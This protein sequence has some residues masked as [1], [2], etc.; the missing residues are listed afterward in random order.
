MTH[1]QS[2]YL[3]V[4]C[5]ALLAALTFLLT[6]IRRVRA[7][8]A[9]MTRKQRTL[10][11]LSLVGLVC[12]LLST[13]ATLLFA[14]NQD[15]P[16]SNDWRAFLGSLSTSVASGFSLGAGLWGSVVASS[17]VPPQSGG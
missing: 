11:G 1:A 7:L 16:V 13:G 8:G 5:A 4:L 6:G 17:P 3:L 9:A 2:I 10:A 15:P 12:M 14:L